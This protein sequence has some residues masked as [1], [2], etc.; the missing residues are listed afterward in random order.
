MLL[1]VRTGA[2]LGTVVLT[3]S[4]LALP[5]A[6]QGTV[7]ATV[8]TAGTAAKSVS[9][10][11]VL[12]VLKGQRL[13][14][15]ATVVVRG[16]SGKARG[17]KAKVKV[18]KKKTVKEVER[19][20]GSTLKPLPSG[21]YRV[22]GR[23]IASQGSEA[24][25]KSV[26]VEVTK[27]KGARAVLKYTSNEPPSS[28]DDPGTSP[29]GPQPT[30]QP[31]TPPADT[32]APAAVTGLTTGSITG[33][34]VKLS[35]TLPPDAD[36]DRVVVR[37]AAGT[38]APAGPS[39][40]QPVALP[41]N[42]KA[43]EFTTDTGL[44]PDKDYAYTVFAQDDSGNT[45]PGASK[46]AKTDDRA[47]LAE[48]YVTTP[49]GEVSTARVVD[50]DTLTD[51][52]QGNGR[53]GPGDVVLL[54]RV[55]T[56]LD[57]TSTTALVRKAINVLEPRDETNDVCSLRHETGVMVFRE[58]NVEQEWTDEGDDGRSSTV[59]DRL[60]GTGDSIRLDPGSPTSPESALDIKRQANSGDDPFLE[61]RAECLTS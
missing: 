52:D 1:G 61:V 9:G 23:K 14:K 27:K 29:T 6:S 49:T 28:S 48:A 17:W 39:D 3:T 34:T 4:V 33:T 10:G 55:A 21:R 40:G 36:L 22:I 25:A 37:R 44:E 30:P 16:V 11:R 35:W 43:S 18:K 45:S 24:R 41:N 58:S 15:K 38:T 8:P 20:N 46:T 47:L 2:A 12:V 60:Q 54:G 26:R 19:A 57:A 59:L 13:G 50:D 51:Q 7:A 31:S 42:A 53:I 56:A 32:T 5:T